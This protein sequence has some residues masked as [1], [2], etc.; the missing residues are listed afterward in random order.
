MDRSTAG[1]QRVDAVIWAVVLAAAA[2]VLCTA[3]SLGFH[4][5]LPS[6][7]A[8]ATASLLLI[9]LAGYYRRDAQ[10]SSAL[11]AT[12]QIVIFAAVGAPLSYL[13]AASAAHVPLWDA[14]FDRFDRALL[15]DWA[16]LRDVLTA[17]PALHELMRSAYY[18]LT[19]QLTGAVL[20]LGFCGEL[21]A[22]RAFTLAFM[23]SALI[24]IAVSAIMPS[25]GVWLFGHF[26]TS[27]PTLV[28]ASGASWP[29]FLGIRDGSYRLLVATG[30]EGIITF[31]SLHA[32]LAAL[33]IFA[34]WRFRRLR[35]PALLL[36]VAMLAATP[37]E[38]AHYL[39]DVLAG[40][41][42]AAVS[43]A[44]AKRLTAWFAAAPENR[45]A[46]R[47]AAPVFR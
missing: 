7:A 15:F 42:V 31:P 19:V 5:V 8:P 18:S 32:G 29:V 10:L 37:T 38:G 28:P 36:N 45:L 4:I 1:L 43:W 14:A 2:L 6:F 12:A 34:F 11:G 24:C 30:A 9:T 33:L 35:W 16:W 46:A 44:A 23:L 47:D 21:L 26:Q 17:S 22:I 41:A 39:A 3:P 27:D 13:A 20:L 40:I 25:E